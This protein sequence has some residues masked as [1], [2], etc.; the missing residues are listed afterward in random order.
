MGKRYSQQEL[1]DSIY[2]Y[3]IANGDKWVT[4][5][6]ICEGIGR[7]KSPHI[8]RMIE[9]LADSGY[10]EKT[11]QAFVGGYTIFFYR[12]LSRVG[13]CAEVEPV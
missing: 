5:K 7:K 4:R 13:A 10:A 12:G 2:N 6:D 1:C 9:H 11:S 3:L 8:L